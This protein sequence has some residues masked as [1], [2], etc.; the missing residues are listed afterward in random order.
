MFMRPVRPSSVGDRSRLSHSTGIEIAGG[1]LKVLF[2]L[3]TI[4]Q[5]LCSLGAQEDIL[6]V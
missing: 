5:M 2:F 3:A 1:S 4:R 6:H